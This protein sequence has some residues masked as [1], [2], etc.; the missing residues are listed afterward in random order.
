MHVIFCFKL[1]DYDALFD[2]PWWPIVLSDLHKDGFV[3]K[4]Y[5]RN[6]FFII[7]RLVSLGA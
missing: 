5:Y 2:L 4:H 3:F 6:Y 7:I 1:S